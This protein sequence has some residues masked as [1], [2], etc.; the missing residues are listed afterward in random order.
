M[1]YCVY[2]NCGKQVYD[3]PGSIR[4]YCVRHKLAGFN[5]DHLKM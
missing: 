4:Q 3:P 1:K 5:N 2:P